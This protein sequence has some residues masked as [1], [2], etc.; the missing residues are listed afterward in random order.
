MNEEVAAGTEH[1]KVPAARG[2]EG[3]VGVGQDVVERHGLLGEDVAAEFALPVAFV[4]SAVAQF[5]EPAGEAVASVVADGHDAQTLT[6]QIDVPAK[7]LE[8]T[9]EGFHASPP[10]LFCSSA[11]SMNGLSIRR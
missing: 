11:S 6:A 1:E 10:F 5:A 8:V 7:G 9:V 3:K 2:E 4:P